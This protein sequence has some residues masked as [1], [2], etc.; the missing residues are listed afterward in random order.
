M[1]VYRETM[2]FMCVCVCELTGGRIGN[3]NEVHS[4]RQRIIVVAVVERQDRSEMPRQKFERFSCRD[5]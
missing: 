3:T 5:G 2:V 4:R 1:P